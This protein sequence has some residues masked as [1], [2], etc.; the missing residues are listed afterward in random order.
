MC[1]RCI[2]DTN[3]TFVI[4][5]WYIPWVIWSWLVSATINHNYVFPLYTEVRTYRFTPVRSVCVCAFSPSVCPILSCRRSN[6]RRWPNAGPTVYDADPTWAQYW[7]TVS[8][9]APRWMWASV[10]DGGPTLTQLWIKSAG[11]ASMKYWL[12]LN[13]YCPA[14]A[15]LAQHLTDIGSVSACTGQQKAMS[16]VQWLMARAGD[17]GPALNQHWVDVCVCWW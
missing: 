2:I 14:P 11:T 4:Q 9:L 1:R 8:C 10:T 3:S 12:G 7:V 5:L 17:G 16:I 13:G 15:T 6:T